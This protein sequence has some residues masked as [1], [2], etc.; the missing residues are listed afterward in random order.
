VTWH[1][2]PMNTASLA[3]LVILGTSVVAGMIMMFKHL[4]ASPE[5]YEDENG[6]HYGRFAQEMIRANRDHAHADMH[7]HQT[8]A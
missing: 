7:E 4:S 1:S 6:F 3:L 5:G 8:A 2:E